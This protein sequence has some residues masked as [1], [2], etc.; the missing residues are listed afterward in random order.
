VI[1]PLHSGYY[2]AYL[3]PTDRFS[4][5]AGTYQES[6][7]TCS[8]ETTWQPTTRVGDLI[9][10]FTERRGAHDDD[11][12]GMRSRD[13]SATECIAVP[14]IRGHPSV[15]AVPDMLPG[16]LPAADRRSRQR[17]RHR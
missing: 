8:T 11:V 12:L 3:E 14:G 6:C 15:P 16:L 1:A 7:I 13:E 9:Y 4:A 10:V 2:R 5:A 17:H